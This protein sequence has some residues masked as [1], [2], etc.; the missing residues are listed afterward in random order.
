MFR[1]YVSF[2]ECKFPIKQG[3]LKHIKTGTIKN[4]DTNPMTRDSQS[5]VLQQSR[6][7][8]T[9]TK[10]PMGSSEFWDPFFWGGGILNLLNF[11]AA[12]IVW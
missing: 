8:T 10:K 1:G 3:S 9:K 7:G 4:R 12:K 2:R 5:Q 11:F 6:T